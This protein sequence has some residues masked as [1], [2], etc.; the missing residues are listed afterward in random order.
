[1]RYAT[2][3]TE[4]RRA[5]HV[6][7]G[8]HR[9]LRAVLED[10]LRTILAARH[11]GVGPAHIRREHAW[12]TSRDRG[13]PFA[14]ESICDALDLDADWIRRLCSAPPAPGSRRSC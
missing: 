1:M 3:S 6:A 14:F 11:G 4:A 13:D 9:L 8:E 2:L 5:D 10:A 7:P 12:M